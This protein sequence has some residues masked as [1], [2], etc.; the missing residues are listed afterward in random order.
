MSAQRSALADYLRARRALLTPEDI[1][2]ST[3]PGRRVKGLRRQEV[4]E[5]A[6]ISLEYYIRLEQG[7]KHQVSDQVLA[8]LARALKLDESGRAYLYRLALPSP[9]TALP[10]P[11]RIGSLVQKL[12]EQWSATPAYIFDRNQDLVFVNDLA[13]VLSPGFAEVGN[14]LVLMLFDAPAEK[15]AEENWQSSARATVAALRFHG[16]PSDPRLQEIVGT[17]SVRDRDFRQIWATHEAR[18]LTSGLAPNFV[19]GFGWVDLPWQILE[20][21]GGH[22][23]NVNVAEPGTPAGDAIRHV[24][25][26]LQ[27]ESTA[28]EAEER[29]SLDEAG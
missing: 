2:R 3:E 17:L 13:A 7:Q 18:P 6:G 28:M 16:D 10:A 5:R 9:V 20:V 21:P 25:T 11:R 8:S 15:R 24:A 23:L 26:R 19:A 1:G 29:F 27:A 4:A 14:N 12:V 22:F